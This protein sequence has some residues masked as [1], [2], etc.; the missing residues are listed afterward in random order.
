M[1]VE[2]VGI[3]VTAEGNVLG[4]LGTTSGDEF[5]SE[6]VHIVGARSVEIAWLD[7]HGSVNVV[8]IEKD[9][10]LQEIRLLHR[11]EHEQTE[12]LLSTGVPE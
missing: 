8:T 1:N 7:Q 5:N 6:K 2:G 4:S 10:E 3:D 9:T 11:R 12:C